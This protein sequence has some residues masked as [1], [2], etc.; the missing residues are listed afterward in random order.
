MGAH[1]SGSRSQRRICLAESPSERVNVGPLRLN[2]EI[3]KTTVRSV[4][5]F[6]LEPLACGVCTPLFLTGT[7]IWSRRLG[8]TNKVW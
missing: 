4:K 5:Q 3:S 8:T 2:S 1:R 6:E 7:A